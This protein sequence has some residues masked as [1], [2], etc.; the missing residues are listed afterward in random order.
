VIKYEENTEKYEDYDEQALVRQTLTQSAYM[1]QS[2]KLAS[3]VQTQF[4]DR[5]QRDNRGVHQAGFYVLW[6][7]SMPS[8]LVELGFLTNSREARYLNSERG[9]TLLA[10]GIFR[11]VRDYKQVY[12]K[13]IYRGE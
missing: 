12:E 9:Q 6:S 10:S 4:E 11:A 13:G 1:R 3:L 2:E 8:V 5:V 7:A